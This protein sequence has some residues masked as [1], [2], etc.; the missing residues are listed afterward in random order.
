LSLAP[1]GRADYVLAPLALNIGPLSQHL[2]LEIACG[3]QGGSPSPTGLTDALG[4]DSIL[5]KPAIVSIVATI[6]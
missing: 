2:L 3:L 4:H 1:D 5:G 6:T